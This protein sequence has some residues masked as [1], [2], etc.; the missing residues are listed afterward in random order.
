VAAVTSPLERVQA[1]LARAVSPETPLEEARSSAVL[2]CKEIVKRGLLSSG[3]GQR[4]A[5]LEADVLRLELR[6][7][8]LTAERE[9]AMPKS[10]VPKR[11][12]WGRRAPQVQ[13]TLSP[14]EAA[15]FIGEVPANW[16]DIERGKK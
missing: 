15:E 14:N 4:I 2:A 6:V 16:A 11:K 13:R 7:L 5:E 1:L 12:R 3:G 8:A 10:S 9:R